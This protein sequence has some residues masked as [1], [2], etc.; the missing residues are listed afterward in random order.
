MNKI[1]KIKYKIKIERIQEEKKI[2][3]GYKN[4]FRGYNL[5]IINS[6]GVGLGCN[7]KTKRELMKEIKDQI[8]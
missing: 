2:P 7:V 5:Q 3:N 8:Y 6:Y 1:N 4:V